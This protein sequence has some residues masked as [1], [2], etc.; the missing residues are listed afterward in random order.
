MEVIYTEKMITLSNV[1]LDL[2]WV[3]GSSRQHG[4]PELWLVG[5]VFFKEGKDTITRG[6]CL[7]SGKEWGSGAP[8]VMGKKWKS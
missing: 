2:W 5:R 4:V 7:H 8:K 3:G 6:K 1:S